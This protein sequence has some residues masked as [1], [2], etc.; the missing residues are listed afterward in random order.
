MENAIGITSMIDS[1][2]TQGLS[3][4]TVFIG[5]FQSGDQNGSRVRSKLVRN[6]WPEQLILQRC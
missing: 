1:Y 5:W 4:T 6:T 2:W 3:E